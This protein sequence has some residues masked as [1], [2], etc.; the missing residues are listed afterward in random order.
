M[1]FTPW[2]RGKAALGGHRACSC[3]RGARGMRASL[4]P[5]G[6]EGSLPLRSHSRTRTPCSAQNAG[7]ETLFPSQPPPSLSLLSLP[8]CPCPPVLALPVSSCPCPACACLAGCCPGCAPL[9]LPCPC[10]CPL[11][12]PRGP[13]RAVSA[14]LVPGPAGT[15]AAGFGRRS[16]ALW[17]G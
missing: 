9:L 13:L 8:R 10:P 1:G 3:A 2:Q 17:D 4:P 11:P 15:A 12:E 16:A 5:A 14:V 7:T 6:T